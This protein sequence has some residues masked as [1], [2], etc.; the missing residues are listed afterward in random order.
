MKGTVYIPISGDGRLGSIAGP[1]KVPA[2]D[3]LF[4]GRIVGRI[5]E[6]LGEKRLAVY[7]RGSLAYGGFIEGLSDLDMVVFSDSFSPGE[8]D[9]VLQIAEEF[10]P[11]SNGRYSLI[12]IS[13]VEAD[14]LHKPEWNRL[15]LNIAL[16]GIELYNSG[17]ALQYLQPL[18]STEMSR[19]IAAQTMSDCSQTL[20]RIEAGTSFE[21]MGRSRGTDFLCVWFARDY[22]RGL[23]AF[24]MPKKRVF[25]LHLETCAY[26]F[27]CC[28]PQYR[29]ITEKIFKAERSPIADRQGLEQLAAKAMTVYSELSGEIL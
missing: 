14:C 28:F 5:A 3:K 12:D 4:V 27:A 10:M 26:E 29:E 1:D 24:V 7:L 13:C 16:T 6:V 11:L 19:R 21:Y 20:D 22:I 2:V 8:R 9:A 25:S 18:F 23:I 15:Y 17:L